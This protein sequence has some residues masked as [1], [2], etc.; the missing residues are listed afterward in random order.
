LLVFALLTRLHRQDIITKLNVSM[1]NDNQLRL[2]IC[3]VM[4]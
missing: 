4:K 3:S 2:S 1:I